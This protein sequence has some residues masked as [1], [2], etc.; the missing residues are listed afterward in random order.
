MGIIMRL[1]QQF[2]AFNETEFMILEKQF[3]D[4]EKR[5]PDFPKG[6]RMQPISA[7]E[8]VNTLIWQYEFPDIESAYKTLD[9]F[10]GDDEHEELFKQQSPLIKQVK[11]EFYKSLDFDQ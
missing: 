3:D 8:P 1:I 11:I 10:N 9:F 7:G 6:K 4:L 5:R 2:D